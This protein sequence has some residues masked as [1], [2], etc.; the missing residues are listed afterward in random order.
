[1]GK[2][3]PLALVKRFEVMN[4]LCHKVIKAKQASK[5]L[6]LSIRQIKR[7]KKR[8]KENNYTLESLAFKRTHPAPNRIP[9]S[10]PKES[11]RPQ[12]TRKVA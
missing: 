3:Y 6:G 8:F 11:S 12:K 10:I 5:E 1:M 9:D 2:S 7:I 4:R